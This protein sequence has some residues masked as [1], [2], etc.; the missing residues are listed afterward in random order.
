LGILGA[1]SETV[2]SSLRVVGDTI[3]RGAYA[4]FDKIAY[5]FDGNTL[6]RGAYENLDQIVFTSDQPI[7]GQLAM[8]LGI[9]ADGAL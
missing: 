5:R 7:S 6:Y 4:Q 9:L 3:Y 8:I 2:V 1:E